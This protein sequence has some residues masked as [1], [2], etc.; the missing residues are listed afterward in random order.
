MAHYQ[1]IKFVRQG[2][3]HMVILYRQQFA[4]AGFYPFLFFYCSA[5]RAMPVSAAM[6]LVLYVPAFTITALIYMIAK[7]RSTAGSYALQHFG[8]MGIFI[9]W[10]GMLLQQLLH[11][12]PGRCIR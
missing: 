4:A 1:T 6:I 10:W 5:I 12:Y 8:Y 2:K 7:S 11:R 3:Y 9:S